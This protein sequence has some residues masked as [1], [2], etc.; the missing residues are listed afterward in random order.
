MPLIRLPGLVDVH[1]HLREP[2]SEQ[3]EDF[4]TGTRAA[5]AGGFT[6][7]LDMPNNP[8]APTITPE[9]LA[10]KQARAAARA[11]CDVGF[12]YG[13][14]PTN[15]ATYP[16]VVDQVFGLKLYLDHTTGALLVEGLAPL[17]AI[18]AAWPSGK[19]L[20]VHAE[21]RTVAAVLG[22]VALRPRRVH[23]AHV[24]RAAEITL[25][26]E[27]KEAG[28]PVTCEVAPHHLFLSDA[29][30]PDLGPYGLMKPPLR[31]GAD[32]DAL[33]ANLPVVDVIA[34]DHAPHTRA[35]K[36][37]GHPGLRR[38]RPA[39]G[40]AADADRGRRRAPHPRPPGRADGRHAPPPLRPPRRAGHLRRGRSRRG[41][42][43]HRRG[44]ADQSRLDAVRRPA[45]AG[46]GAPGRP[47]RR[48]GRAR[49]H[50]PSPRRA[51]GGC[52]GPDR[53]ATPGSAPRPAGH[54]ITTR[55]ATPHQP[56]T[57]GLRSLAAYRVLPRFRDGSGANCAQQVHL[58]EPRRTV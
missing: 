28:L 45:G 17:L 8:G 53:A 21:E 22:V 14:T 13:A 3:K 33:W 5:L 38:A 52:C 4:A 15:L 27:A 32:V 9:A 6:Q 56:G 48:R 16:A 31:T 7:V 1:V 51:A 57:C 46:P 44:P 42:D 26:R 20:I 37:F 29:D 40:P 43:D 35:E 41:L 10:D 36:E 19:P 55:Q 12:H 18:C 54:S 34:T 49:R 30:L 47:A 39:D 50:G 24:S 2:G 25:I 58:R 11:C 23:F